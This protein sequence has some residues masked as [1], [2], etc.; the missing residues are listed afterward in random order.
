MKQGKVIAILLVVA[1]L[2]YYSWR[3]NTK[4]AQSE[5]EPVGK[6]ASDPEAVRLLEQAATA[7]KAAKVIRYDA[8]YTERGDREHVGG[9]VE[10]DRNREWVKMSVADRRLPDYRDELFDAA[11]DGKRVVLVSHM[12]MTYTHGAF[13]E[14]ARIM[15][16]GDDLLIQQFGRDDAFEAEIKSYA[17]HEG[18][19]SVGD[20]ECDVVYIKHKQDGEY[21]RWFFGPDGL[22]RCVERISNAYD[23]IPDSHH[24]VKT[25]TLSDIDLQPELVE[26]GFQLERPE[27][28]EDIE[29]K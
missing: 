29:L 18:R 1:G 7:V 23:D 5:A 12:D 21:S 16:R 17:V 9:I 11:T 26:T 3:A 19:R 24:V 6:K 2:G 4:P 10:L 13:P 22:P 20:V 8:D 28:Y 14:R 27:D 25:L 15:R